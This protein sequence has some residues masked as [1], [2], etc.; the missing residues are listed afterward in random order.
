MRVSIKLGYEH[1]KRVAYIDKVDEGIS[2]TV[3]ICQ[4]GSTEVRS[5]VNSLA[6]IGKVDAQIHE[7]VLSPAGLVDNSLQHCLI[8]LVGNVP[9]HDLV[10]SVNG[11]LG[12]FKS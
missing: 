6:V 8:H 2:N 10:S 12:P 11:S 1:W 4:S 7:V 3:H 5:R 9:E